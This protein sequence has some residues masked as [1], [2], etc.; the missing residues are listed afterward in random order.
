MNSLR[1]TEAFEVFEKVLKINSIVNFTAAFQNLL[2]IEKRVEYF[3]DDSR[4][5]K[6]AQ[7]ILILK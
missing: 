1:L 2:R 7:I 4:K 6:Q 3:V 5:V